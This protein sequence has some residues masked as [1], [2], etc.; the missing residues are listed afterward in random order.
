LKSSTNTTPKVAE[1]GEPGERHW[2]ILELKLLAD[3]GLVGLPNAGKST[4]LSVITRAQPKIA[5]YPFTTLEPNLGV[6]KIP[7]VGESR[8][9]ELVI[10][11]IPGLI[12]GAAEGK[13]LGDEFL[14]HIERCK[15]LVHLV[16]IDLT[17]IKQNTEEPAEEN[18]GQQIAEQLY[19]DFEVINKELGGYHPDMLKKPQIVVVN[20]TDLLP[21]N[22]VSSIRKQVLGEF[23]KHGVKDV[24]FI[25][26][27]TN[28]GI[29]ELKKELGEKVARS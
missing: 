12:E 29:E 22:L 24:L 25:S 28:Q 27:A 5:D 4:L 14:R 17:S 2:V 21:A 10:A 18:S 1:P 8:E 6:L 19:S 3:V 13:G 20:K 7:V 15:V 16:A 11:D 23:K 26:A 9:R